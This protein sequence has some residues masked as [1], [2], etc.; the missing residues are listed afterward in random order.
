MILVTGANGYLGL[1]TI[2]NLRRI[3]PETEVS[4]LVRSREKG[5]KVSEAGA[6]VKIGDYFDPASL[7]KAFKNIDVLL[8]ISSSTIEDR[9]KQHENVIRAAEKSGVKQLVYTS[10]VKA[11]E[12]IS[13]LAY[14][15]AETE[16]I[17][18]RSNIE[19][20]ISRHT[21]YSELFPMFLGNALDTGQ[22]HFPS[23]GEKMNVA[24]RTEMGEALAGILAD[25]DPH[26]GKTYELTSGSAHTFTELSEMLSNIS[27]KKIT[28]TDVPVDSYVEQLNKAGL[29]DEV[30]GMAKLS[31]ETVS[32]G[33]L[34]ITTSDLKKLLGRKPASVETFIKEFLSQH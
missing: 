13:P 23:S 8:L 19:T 25:P 26:R 22:W 30:V 28:Y 31:A 27:G 21:F 10:M 17:L 14:D 20:T 29:P 12:K 7:E 24:F 3:S 15:H 18:D 33:A 32:S 4:G 9:V 11:S 2:R 1:E 34:D 6:E 16:E 5:E